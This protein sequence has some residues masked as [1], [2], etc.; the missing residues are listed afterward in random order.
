MTTLVRTDIVK[1]L[2]SL[3]AGTDGLRDVDYLGAFDVD[4]L[5]EKCGWAGD[6]SGPN[7]FNLLMGG[8]DVIFEADFTIDFGVLYAVSNTDAMDA[9]I[10]CE[11]MLKALQLA[12]A[13]DITLG[14]VAADAFDVV[15]ANVSGPDAVPT[16]SGWGGAGVLTI[17]VSG[18]M[19]GSA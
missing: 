13:H 16:E 6:I 9:R 7:D 10:G 4:E 8:V 11:Q 19:Q 14:G 18:S 1:G 17:A 12:V 5:T 2:F 3:W 15:P